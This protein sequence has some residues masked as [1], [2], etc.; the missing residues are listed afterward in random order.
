MRCRTQDAVASVFLIVAL[1]APTLAA[2]QEG[3]PDLPTVAQAVRHDTSPPLRDLVP[4]PPQRAIAN[5]QIRLRVPVDLADRFTPS[6]GREDPI[7]QTDDR[8]ISEA[9]VTPET[10]TNFEGLSDDDNFDQLGFRVVP[11]D[12][13]GDVSREYYVQFINLIFAVWDKNNLDTDT[14]PI[15]GPVA[16]NTIWAGFGGICETNND[17]DPIVLYDHLA[18]RWVFSQFAIG[19]RDG[20]QCIAVSTTP[21]PRDPYHRYDFLVSPRAVNDYPKLGV[22]PDGYYMTANEFG[23]RGFR[24]A[25][26][27]AFERKAMLK[28]MP[29]R[30]AKAGPL[31]CGSECFFS[32]QPSHLEG[33]PPALGTPNTFLMAFDDQTWGTGGNP[34]GYRL[35]DFAVDWVNGVASFTSL[36]QV[37]TIEFDANMCN[38]SRNC[39]PQLAGEGLDSLSQFTMY[40]AQYRSFGT[41]DSI[42][43]NHTVDANGSDLAGVRWAELRNTGAGWAVYQ[44]GTYAPDGDHRWMGS[45]AMDGAGNIALGY[46]VSSSSTTNPSVRYVT[47]EAGDDLGLLPG[48]EVELIAGTGSQTSSFNRWGD[49][50]TMSVDPVDDCTF[51][52]TQEYYANDGSFDFKTRIGSFKLPSCGGPPSVNITTTSLN[53]G[54]VGTSY[55]QTLSATGGTT[56]YSWSIASG[57]LPAGLLLNASTGVISETPTTAGTSNFTVQVTDSSSPAQTDTQALSISIAAVLNITTTNLPNG[58]VGVAYSETL[59]ATGGTTPYSWSIAS[60]SLPAGLSLNASTGVIFGTLSTAGTS[61]FTVQVTDSASPAQTD[62][63][64]LSITVD[65]APLNITATS[66]PDGT[67]NEAYSATLQA[68]GGTPPYSWA[69]TAGDLPGG[70]SL[71]SATGE[72]SGIPTTAE[73]QTFTVTVTDGTAATD[74]QELSIT[75]AAVVPG[76]TVTI[77]KANHSSRKVELKVEATSS[78]GGPLDTS[79]T[80]TFFY[81]TTE[82][83]V[84]GKTMTYNAKKDKWSVTFDSGDELTT[85]P[86][87]VRVSSTNTFVETANIG[88][89]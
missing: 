24:G 18:D 60:G 48:G 84:G 61:N 22:W 77:T 46:S 71:N 6:P 13:N 63:Q 68:T 28:G 30:F 86:D 15:F 7:R 75:I 9:S 40:R 19:S 39:I 51:W 45:I 36:G 10:S 85:K 74:S 17:G 38:F 37:D 66:L 87:K 78:L 12:T 31:N 55:S 70:L 35:W 11:P 52:Y 33:P 8:P 23:K 67:E 49:Y 25:I 2:A 34:D 79:L 89:K 72:I 3:P 43:V 16:G 82:L 14:N 4:L 69:I 56:P 73:T 32:L 81:G 5:R 65:L 58:T 20:H 53:D 80:A 26:A 76:D 59:Q 62:T 83:P 27:V 21:D 1:S 50:S 47:R 54:I 88:G 44:T 57:S 64:A 41:H 29:A 42:V